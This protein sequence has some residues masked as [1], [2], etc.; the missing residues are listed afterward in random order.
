MRYSPAKISAVWFASIASLVI[1]E[2]LFQITKPSFLSRNG[3]VQNV[4]IELLVI[5]FLCVA[6]LPFLMLSLGLATRCRQRT[7][8]KIILLGVPALLTAI[9]FLLMLDNFTHTVLAFNIGDVTGWWRFAYL[10]LLLAIAADLLQRFDRLTLA[11]WPPSIVR[12]L[13]VLAASAFLFAVG[14]LPGRWKESVPQPPIPVI[15][16][17]GPRPNILILSTDGLR[18]AS[19][20]VY[21][22]PRPTTPFLDSIA[23]ETLRFNGHFPNASHTTGSLMALL[24]GRH[25]TSNG[26]IYRP[27]IFR[28]INAFQHLPGILRALGY[29]NMD[30]SLD[31]YADPFDLNMRGA[32]DSANFRAERSAQ[33]AVSLPVAWQVRFEGEI[34]FI[35]HLASRVIQRLAHVLGLKNL[36]NPYFLVTHTGTENRLDERTLARVKTLIEDS[37]RPFF[38]HVHLLGTHGPK[39][40]P[41]KRFFSRGKTQDQEW[42]EDFYDDAIL[43]FD[44]YVEELFAHMKEQKILDRTIVIL[45]SDHGMDFTPYQAVPLIFRYPGGDRTGVVEGPSQ[46]IDVAPTLLDYLEVPVPDWMDG[47]SLTGIGGKRVEPIF[48]VIPG[49]LGQAAS[50]WRETEAYSPPFYSLGALGLISGQRWYGYLIK[51]NVL[52]CQNVEGVPSS[53]KNLKALSTNQVQK[54]MVEHLRNKGYKSPNHR[55]AIRT[56]NC[57]EP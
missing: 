36:G 31:Y 18:A 52:Y 49:K 46:Q 10:F 33:L 38:L 4:K 39:F 6:I 12:S 20:S 45:T 21:G 15:S 5:L 23:K 3:F 13:Q 55:A 34:C 11:F 56:I 19:M 29:R 27:D 40:G 53:D 48:S 50:G 35:E 42:M 2:W 22:Y 32:F 9:T 47:Q 1:T 14:V 41:P 54:I 44:R 30:V 51:E 17:H 26:V 24:S 28:G 7:V 37:P 8:A 16:T 25:P 43:A 57:P